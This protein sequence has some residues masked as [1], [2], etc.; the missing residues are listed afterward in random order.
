MP[1]PHRPVEVPMEEHA[2]DAEVAQW[3]NN[4]FANGN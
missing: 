3:H 1:N 2:F 4:Y